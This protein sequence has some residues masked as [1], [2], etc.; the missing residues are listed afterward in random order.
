MTDQDDIEATGTADEP[1]QHP[2]SQPEREIEYPG[3]K[4]LIRIADVAS[5]VSLIYLALSIIYSVIQTIYYFFYQ[6]PPDNWSKLDIYSIAMALIG[7]IDS[8][9]LALFV[10]LV[11]QAVGEIIYLLMDIRYLLQPEKDLEEIK[12]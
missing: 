11:L 4:K 7:R 1:V 5:T 2:A 10:F 12:L 9:L 3:D 8:V 6:V